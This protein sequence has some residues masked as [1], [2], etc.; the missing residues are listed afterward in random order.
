[1]PAVDN[2]TKQFR[3]ATY[4]NLVDEW[5]FYRGKVDQVFAKRERERDPR[6]TFPTHKHLLSQA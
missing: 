4:R 3:T 2:K 6:W 1:M 5:S